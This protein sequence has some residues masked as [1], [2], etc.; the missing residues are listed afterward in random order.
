MRRGRK[1]T[2]DSLSPH[3]ERDRLRRR[4]LPAVSAWIIQWVPVDVAQHPLEDAAPHSR[5]RVVGILSPRI[6][7]ERVCEIAK[8]IYIASYAEPTAMLALLRTER[9]SPRSAA[10]SPVTPEYAMCEIRWEDGKV[11]RVPFVDRL[12]FGRDPCLYAR[13]VGNLRESDSGELEWDEIP[14]PTS[15]GRQ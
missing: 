4:R 14:V 9:V 12:R 5:R 10:R 6:S 3:P 2:A 1:I 8:A 11:R 7:H 15:G 13:K